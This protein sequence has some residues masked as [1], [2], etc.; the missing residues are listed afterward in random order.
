MIK[1]FKKGSYRMSAAAVI[2]C[3]LA[4]GI[5]FT[6]GVTAKDMK[7][8]TNVSPVI[9]KENNKFLIDSPIKSY[10]NLKK[11]EKIAGA[12]IKVPNYIP[13]NYVVCPIFHV[14]KISDKDCSL[15]I[16]FNN[17]KEDMS[18]AFQ[19]S[20]ENMEKGLE[21]IAK[22]KLSSFDD[23]NQ[24]KVEFTKEAINLA[25]IN[26][27][28]ITIK[29]T[30][31]EDSEEISKFFVWQNEGMWYS[32]EYDKKVKTSQVNTRL[33]GIATDEV[34]KIASSIKYFE[35]AKNVN[36]AVSEKKDISTGSPA[37][38]RIYDK[39]DLKKSKELLGFNPKFP[40]R[41]NKNIIVQEARVSLS[42]DSDI[43]NEKLNYEFSACSKAKVGFITFTQGKSGKKYEDIRK[44]V[45]PI[46]IDGK[47]VFKYETY[48]GKTEK[49]E[50]LKNKNY[51]WEENGSYC[52]VSILEGNDNPDEIAKAFVN[53]KP[54]D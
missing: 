38:I 25:G 49:G 7:G 35:D 12:K 42:T 11:A 48:Y 52:E 45:N 27:S 14:I 23:T 2:C 10:D 21:Q 9:N 36:Y 13:A 40:L 50:N 34:G 54:I 32:I 44:K 41:I 30:L 6:N 19:A 8:N 5:M 33:L 51:I 24:G 20:K 17:E 22:H 46:K 43:K 29:I 28:N 18:F 39:E 53:S 37:D 26:G 15:R 47:E 31:P 16:L 1:N 3:V 4:G